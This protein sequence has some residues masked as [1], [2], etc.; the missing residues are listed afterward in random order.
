MTCSRCTCLFPCVR[1]DRCIERSTLEGATCDF[2]SLATANQLTL[3]CPS[4]WSCFVFLCFQDGQEVVAVLFHS[5][6]SAVSP[7][8]DSSVSC[9]CSAA[10]VNPVYECVSEFSTCCRFWL[11]HRLYMK[12]LLDV[13]CCLFLKKKK[14][15]LPKIIPLNGK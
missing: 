2:G 4:L 6:S 8:T 13:A 10:S 15:N 11:E 14:A 1:W 9:S 7:W 12:V 3:T 5:D